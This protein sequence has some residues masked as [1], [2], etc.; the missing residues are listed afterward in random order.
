MMNIS[1]RK[2]TENEKN[3]FYNLNQLF[4]YDFSEL[5]KMNI[6]KD[7]LYQ[8][9]PDIDDYY[10][11][12]EYISFFINV[13]GELAGLAVVKFIDEEEISYL[14][15]FFIIR[16]YRRSKIG[17]KSAHMI[18]DMFPGKWRVSQFD[19]NEPAICF[20]RKIIERYV[21]GNYIE[22]RRSDDKGIQQE[23]FSNE[24]ICNNCTSFGKSNR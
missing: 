3:T 5:N 20:W 11:K 14:R 23:F 2:V 8:K 24:C 6:N 7:G 18:F 1:L 13:E 19:F 16:K 22:I 21:N 10:T 17:E 12:Q 4:A 15:H 9:L